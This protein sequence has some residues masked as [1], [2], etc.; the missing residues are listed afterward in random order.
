MKVGSIVELS[1]KGKYGF[2]KK[3]YLNAGMGIVVKFQ[4]G[5][6]HVHGI[7]PDRVKVFWALTGKTDWNDCRDLE[8][9][10]K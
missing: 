10:C 2:L 8:Q 4:K 7:I 6:V 3:K 9:V 5:Q 1:A